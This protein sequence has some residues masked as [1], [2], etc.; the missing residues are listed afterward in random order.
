MMK[1]EW[2]KQNYLD[3]LW[4]AIKTATDSS[5]CGQVG[6]FIYAPNEHL[7]SEQFLSLSHKSSLSVPV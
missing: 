2:L 6:N 1:P 5:A 3:S 7:E 4:M